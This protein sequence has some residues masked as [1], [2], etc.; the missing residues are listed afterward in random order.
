M[1]LKKSALHPDASGKTQKYITALTTG[2]TVPA[3]IYAK[4]NQRLPTIIIPASN[5]EN[6]F[7]W[8]G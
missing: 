3:S 4:N 1:L 2:Y 5:K 8:L 7:W 6:L